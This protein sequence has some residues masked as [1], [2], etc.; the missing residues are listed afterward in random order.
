MPYENI[1]KKNCIIKIRVAANQVRKFPFDIFYMVPITQKHIVSGL[2]PYSFCIPPTTAL[3]YLLSQLRVHCVD[4]LPHDKRK[5]ALGVH[6]TTDLYLLTGNRL[7]YYFMIIPILPLAPLASKQNK[8]KMPGYLVASTH[9]NNNYNKG[10][11]IFA[12]ILTD[13]VILYT[14][15]GPVRPVCLHCP[16]HM[17][18]VLDKCKLGSQDCLE[19]LILEKAPYE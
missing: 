10:Y 1:C 3:L 13:A 15:T 5:E 9:T 4:Y 17:L 11:S 18:H 14:P 19:S 16:K 2:F 8:T 7:Q 12:N 6:A